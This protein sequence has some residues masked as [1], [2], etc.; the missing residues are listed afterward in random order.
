[1]NHWDYNSFSIKIKITEA[2]LGTKGFPAIFEIANKMSMPDNPQ[3]ICLTEFYFDD[4]A[5]LKCRF[6]NMRFR[7]G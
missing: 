1:M 5:M 3:G 2:I 7:T 4:R 6:Q